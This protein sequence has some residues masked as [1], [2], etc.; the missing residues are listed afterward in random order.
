MVSLVSFTFYG[1]NIFFPVNFGVQMDSDIAA[2]LGG[3][4]GL[5]HIQLSNLFK[6]HQNLQ[7][8]IILF[9]NCETGNKVKL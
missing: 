3:V 8:T 6:T 9:I 7:E 4:E 2:I 5:R 1:E